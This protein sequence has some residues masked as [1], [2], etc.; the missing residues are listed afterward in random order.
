MVHLVYMTEPQPFDEISI[1][2]PLTNEELFSRLK[3]LMTNKPFLIEIASA[4]DEAYR[5][6]EI[7]KRKETNESIDEWLQRPLFS[8]EEKEILLSTETKT[9]D[10]QQIFNTAQQK[11]AMNLAGFYSVSLGLGVIAGDN[12]DNQFCA[13]QILTA[14]TQDKDTP[15][16][17]MLMSRLAHMTWAAG[18]PFRGR[19]TR[20]VMMPWD[21]LPPE[22][23]HKDRVQIISAARVLLRNILEP[24]K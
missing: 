20:P 19:E 8:D 14:I 7:S 10:Q 11:L 21:L 23:K 22:E 2:E 9:P 18:Q 6:H 12:Q 1:Q 13:Q 16:I 17:R 5:L 3:K 15:K 24:N 4:C